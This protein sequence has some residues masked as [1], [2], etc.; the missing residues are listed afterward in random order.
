M[1]TNEFHFRNAGTSNIDLDV[2]MGAMDSTLIHLAKTGNS[3]QWGTQP[4]SEKEGYREESKKDM[5][6][7]ENYRKTGEGDPRRCFIA[8]VED[9]GTEDGLLRRID[10]QGRSWLPVGVIDVWENKMVGYVAK[11][12]SLK[13]MHD[14][15]KA[16]GPYLYIEFLISD[17]RTGDRAKGAGAALIEYVKKVAREKGMKTAYVDCWV[18][19]NLGLVK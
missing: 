1:P 17:F 6:A 12:E 11:D 8:E 14:Q 7:S 19:G 4:F 16:A 5:D 18:G 2:M 9:A 13:E 10:D 3:E 15:V